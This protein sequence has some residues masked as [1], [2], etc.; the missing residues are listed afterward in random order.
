MS[1]AIIVFLQVPRKS[2][3]ERRQS[4]EE[5]KVESAKQSKQ[6]HIGLI[7]TKKVTANGDMADTDKSMKQK[8]TVGKRLS[9]DAASLGLPGNIVKVSLSNRRLTDAAVSW[10]SLPSSIAKLGKVQF[11]NI[12]T[13]YSTLSHP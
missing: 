2:A 5:N 3:S 7:S 4:K 1:L 9:G 11:R 13:L 12:L 8:T 6:E 10:A